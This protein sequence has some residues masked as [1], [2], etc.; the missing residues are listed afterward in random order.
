MNLKTFAKPLILE[1]LKFAI[2]FTLA[3]KS[4]ELLGK[5]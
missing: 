1:L 3:Y 2:G 5:I 4:L